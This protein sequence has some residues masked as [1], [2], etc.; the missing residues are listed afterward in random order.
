MAKSFAETIAW[1][2]A[3]GVGQLHVF[4]GDDLYC[5]T[6]RSFNVAV[7]VA[8]RKVNGRV[9]NDSGKLVFQS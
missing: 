7:D 8:K 6:W 1:A 4:E 9:Y 3:R 5:S 2:N